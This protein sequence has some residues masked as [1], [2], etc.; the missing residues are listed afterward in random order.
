VI[1]TTDTVTPGNSS[2]T[3]YHNG[4]LDQDV[5]GGGSTA[6][7]IPTIAAGFCAIAGTDTS[8]FPFAGSLDDVRFYTRAVTASDILTYARQP[9]PVAAG[10]FVAPTVVSVQQ[11][12][13]RRGVSQ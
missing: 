1:F 5:P 4:V 3:M 12:L 11:R 2:V 8:I 10:L 6:Y 13:R 7:A 9:D